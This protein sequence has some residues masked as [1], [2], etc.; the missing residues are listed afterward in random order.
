MKANLKTLK[1]ILIRH[2]ESLVNLDS[3]LIGGQ[4]PETR[5]AG[6]FGLEIV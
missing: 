3:H 6:N 4:S 2:G 1:L 5:L